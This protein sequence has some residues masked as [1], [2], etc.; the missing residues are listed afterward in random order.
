MEL[1][2][3]VMPS[4]HHTISQLSGRRWMQSGAVSVSPLWPSN[5][6]V[7]SIYPVACTTS[8]LLVVCFF[9]F[10]FWPPHR[11]WSS[12][13]RNRI[14]AS[15]ATY[16]AAAP[17]QE[18]LTHCAGPGIEPAFWCCELLQIPLHYSGKS[19]LV[20]LNWNF[21]RKGVN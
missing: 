7:H 9:L 15:A 13:V 1:L 17:M 4:S 21:F 5:K 12:R 8:I 11:M 16:T 6:L 20:F 2:L 10:L 19:L 14:Q 3:L 18:F